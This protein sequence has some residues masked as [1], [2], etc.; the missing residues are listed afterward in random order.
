MVT[1]IHHFE[2][3]QTMSLEEDL[4]SVVREHMANQPYD[5]TC[6]ECRRQVETETEVDGDGDMIVRVV[7]CADCLDTAKTEAHDEGK[8]EGLAEAEDS[9]E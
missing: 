4:T 7:P 9:K 2:R 6:M 1:T 5:I 3:T 8:A